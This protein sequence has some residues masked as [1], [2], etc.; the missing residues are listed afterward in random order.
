MK[1]N[2]EKEKHISF[3]G[4]WGQKCVKKTLKFASNN[5]ALFAASTTLALSTGIRP[6]VILATPNTK[7]ENKEIACAKSI[8][9]GFLEFLITL[10]ISAPIVAS[11]KKIDKNPQKYLKQESIEKLSDGLNNLKNSKAYSLATQ[12]FKLGVS[13]AV[14]IPKSILT[15]TGIPYVLDN[16]MNKNKNKTKKKTQNLTFQGKNND[17]IT[18]SLG[19]ILDNKTLQ[20]FSLKNKDSNFPMHIFALKDIFAT[21]AFIY[22]ANKNSKINEEQKPFLVKNSIISTLL[23]ILSSYTIDKMTDKKSEKIINLIKKENF[24]DKNL[25]KYI[26]GFK[27]I[28]PITI[29]ALVYYTIIP[30]LS[31]FF[32]QNS[33]EK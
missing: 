33:M 14:V 27:I 6:L 7:K 29:L 13:F 28:K 22:Q 3:N 18:K 21:T 12:L 31:T 30:S 9:S 16:I 20:E 32:A 10:A 25:Y 2:S 11:L 8:I 5:G 1:V 26:E 23:S 17:I 15:A 19:K 4:F 24:N